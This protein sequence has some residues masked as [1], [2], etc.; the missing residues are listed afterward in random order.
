VPDNGPG[1]L[2]DRAFGVVETVLYVAAAVV[3]GLAALALLVATAAGLVRDL[4]DGTAEAV[5]TALDTLLLAFIVIELLAA[6][7]AS[8]ASRQ[9][10][11]E[12]FLLV[13]MIASIKEIVVLT[14]LAREE[15]GTPEA[16]DAVVQ[17]GVLG[18]LVLVL[19]A[20]TYLVRRKEREPAED[21]E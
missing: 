3:L 21:G 17:I 20:A 14:L 5:T 2:R 6:V 9:L 15:L 18:A 10:V 7:R 1:G 4:G 13:G 11:A 19:S 12:P 8:V 16:D